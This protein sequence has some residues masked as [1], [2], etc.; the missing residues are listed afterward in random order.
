[1]ERFKTDVDLTRRQKQILSELCDGKTYKEIGGTLDISPRT[2]RYH[3]EEL[4]HHFMW[5]TGLSFLQEPGVSQDQ[6][7]NT[8]AQ[9]LWLLFSWANV[10]NH[11]MKFIYN[12]GS[13]Y[14][15]HFL[16]RVG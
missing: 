6:R 15:F 4:M 12:V 10:K 5:K 2:V 11:K 14:N 16:K 3:V 13:Y 9:P 1:M 8:S 7:N